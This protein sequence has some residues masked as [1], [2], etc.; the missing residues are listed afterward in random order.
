MSTPVLIALARAAVAA[1]MAYW[2][3]LRAF[4]RA[5]CDPKEGTWLD[6]TDRVVTE[7]LDSLAVGRDTMELVEDEDLTSLVELA[8]ADR[9]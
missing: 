3:A 5:S 9:K 6:H 4:E 2:D 8:L 1:K 7:E